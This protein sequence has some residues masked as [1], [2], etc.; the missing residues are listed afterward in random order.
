MNPSHPKYLSLPI[1]EMG[2]SLPPRLL[3]EAI[4]K[5]KESVKCVL[6]RSK[7]EVPVMI[8]QPP[9]AG[10]QGPGKDWGPMTLPAQLVEN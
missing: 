2:S 10:A 8:M 3:G 4:E 6:L 5:L 7:T 9:H 1:C